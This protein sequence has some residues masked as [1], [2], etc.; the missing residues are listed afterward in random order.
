M[1]SPKRS[2]IG[3]DI[4]GTKIACVER[5]RAGQIHPTCPAGTT[6]DWTSG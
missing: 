2:L 1:S 3:L 4:G 5:T 6:S